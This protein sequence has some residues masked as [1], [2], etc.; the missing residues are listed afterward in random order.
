MIYAAHSHVEVNLK[1]LH[2]TSYIKCHSLE[3]IISNKEDQNFSIFDCKTGKVIFESP[4][5]KENQIVYK[6]PILFVESEITPEVKVSMNTQ[7]L[8]III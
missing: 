8:I 6:L 5:L 7:L 3:L 1:S 2:D 4:L